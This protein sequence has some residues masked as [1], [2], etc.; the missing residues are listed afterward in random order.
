[1]TPAARQMFI[2][3]NVPDAG[4]VWLDG[5]PMDFVESATDERQRTTDADN[6]RM[7]LSVGM[8]SRNF[9]MWGHMVDSD[10]KC[11]I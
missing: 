9:N 10:A 2:K 7:R 11:N 8:S 1:M 3:L 5:K 6:N 4:T